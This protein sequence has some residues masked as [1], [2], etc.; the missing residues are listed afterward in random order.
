MRHESQQSPHTQHDLF[1]GRTVE[2][3]CLISLL[4]RAE[5]RIV[6]ISGVSGI[7]KTALLERFA[8]VARACGA[9]FLRLDCRDVEP[10]EQGLLQAMS[11]ACG[12]SRPDLADIGERLSSVGSRIIVAFDTYELF[13]LMDTFIRQQLCPALA[14]NVRLI[15]SG[16]DGPVGEW[17]SGA[18]RGSL[19]PIELDRLTEQESADYLER[20]GT[21]PGSA[22]RINAIA[23]GHPLSLTVAASLSASSG[24]RTIEDVTAGT[25]I[26]SLASQYLDRVPD[27]A[28]RE[29]LQAASVLRRATA[30]TL[31]AMLPD[32]APDDVQGR[33]LRLPFVHRASDGL[34]LHDAIREA[35]A[36]QLQATDPERH[37]RY[38]R[39]A[40]QQL[41]EEMRSAPARSYWRYTADILYLL[42]NPM[43][44]EGFFPSGYQTLAVEA[45]LPADEQAILEIAGRHEGP[46]GLAITRAWWTMQPSAFL[47]C[48][49]DGRRVTGYSIQTRASELAPGISECDPVTAEWMRIARATDPLERALLIRRILDFDAGEGNSGSRGALALDAKRLYMELRPVLRYIYLGGHRPEHFDWC[50]PL[51]F[52]VIQEARYVFDGTLFHSYRLDMGPGSVDGW[53]TRLV[54][55]ELGIG[56][57]ETGTAVFDA[58]RRELLLPEGPVLLTTLEYDVMKALTERAGRPASR[59]DLLEEVWGFRSEATS[60]V[61]DAVIASLRRKLGDERRVI[62]TVRGTGYRFNGGTTQSASRASA[63]SAAQDRSNGTAGRKTAVGRSRVAADAA[64]QRP[65]EPAQRRT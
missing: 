37:N 36:L 47:V 23:H 11:E 10:S 65:T 21:D 51:G 39:L 20:L 34:Y 17:L 55:E 52:E 32:S 59:A 15:L 62:E 7:G 54:G 28:S 64:R 44:R 3:Q 8:D 1:V 35:I 56:H 14:D 25:V 13:W 57:A 53:L 38:R 46:E 41:R 9:T 31:G 48:R 40:W 45:A 26:E 24:A 19:V 5:P 12:A 4:E 58:D 33:L 49:G 61:V 42:Q 6:H 16:R 22:F 43:I 18:W 63:G 30:S 2:L 60:N 27:A 29:A 50:D